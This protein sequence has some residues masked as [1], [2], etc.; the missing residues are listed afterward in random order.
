[1]RAVNG[2]VGK[3]AVQ[4]DVLLAVGVKQDVVMVTRNG[5]HRLAVH[6]RVVE[7]VEEVDPTRA[8]GRQ[9]AAEPAGKLRVST[10]REG[11]RLLVAHLDEAD[12]FLPLPQHLPNA[13]N[14]VPGDPKDD[15]DAP[16]VNRVDQH[17]GGS[18]GGHGLYSSDDGRE[19]TDG[20]EDPAAG[21]SPVVYRP[22]SIV[23]PNASRAS[24]VAGPF[25]RRTS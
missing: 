3:D 25:L 21:A 12:L 16:V 14:P 7:A 6:L 9:A 8:G 13:V 20:G 24:P 2:H 19:T 17:V 5:K 18:G 4:G 11:G 23:S 10:R 1:A 15:F 22:S